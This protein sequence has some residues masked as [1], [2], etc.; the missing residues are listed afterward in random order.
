[1]THPIMTVEPGVVGSRPAPAGMP[2]ARIAPPQIAE[3]GDPFST[4]RVIDAVAR[5]DRGRPIRLDDLVDRLNATHLDW[6]FTRAVVADTL[7]ALQANWM[8]DYRNSSGIVLEPSA[9]G[10]TVTLE[11][12]SRVDPWIVGQAQRAADASRQVLE[13][14]ARRD[15]VAGE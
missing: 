14:F 5:M 10:D 3:P 4:L 15:R 13:E 8:A 11:D 1:M 9:Y 6:L 12:S 2:D 7:V